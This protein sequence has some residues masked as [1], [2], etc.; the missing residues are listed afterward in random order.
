M[1]DHLQN[2]RS[3]LVTDLSA[4]FED[5][6]GVVFGSDKL[7][8]SGETLAVAHAKMTTLHTILTRIDEEILRRDLAAES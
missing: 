8:K 7:T 3:F 2:I 5:G 1:T 6:K 4:T